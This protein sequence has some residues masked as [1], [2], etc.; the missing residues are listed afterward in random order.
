MALPLFTAGI[1][2]AVRSPRF[3]W[4][5]VAM[6][7]LLFLNG[8]L[9]LLATVA[10]ATYSPG[11]ITGTLLYLPFGGFALFS[12]S[13]ALPRPVFARAVVGGIVFHALISIAAFV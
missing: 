2:G 6:S 1:F 13:Q 11:T 3:A 12:M 10:F 4:V 7:A 5:V 8:A 9:H